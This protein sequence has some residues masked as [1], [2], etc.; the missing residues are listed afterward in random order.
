MKKLLAVLAVGLL[1]GADDKN[2]K[3]EGTWK[4]V[5]A[6]QNGME[7]PDAGEHTLT[8]AGDMFT[9][10]RNGETLMKGAFKA[11]DTKKPKT[12]DFIVKE[13]QNDGKTIVAIYELDGDTLKWCA[14]D[15]GN[16]ERPTELSSGEGS[17]RLLVTL[18]R[19]KK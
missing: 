13:G 12:I 14:A 11:D 16:T 1:L 17:K 4:A 6:V 2:D 19:E 9:V 18:K 8:F 15:P 10:T 3:L 7:Q 5:K